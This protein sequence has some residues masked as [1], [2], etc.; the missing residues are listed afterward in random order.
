MEIN[1]ILNDIASRR[2][3]LM[4]LVFIAKADGIIEPE[5]MAFFQNA[6]VAMELDEASLKKVNDCW[7]SEKCPPLEFSNSL[8]KK[9]FIREAIE[10]SCINEH[11]AGEERACVRKFAE[12]LGVSAS[13]VESLEQWVNEGMAWKKRGD[14][15]IQDEE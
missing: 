7:S 11:Y 12:E 5:E 10:L 2:S 6:A 15:L 14:V 4:G 8:Q 13:T 9:F 1:G 3:F